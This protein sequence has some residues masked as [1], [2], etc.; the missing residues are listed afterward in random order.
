MI[1]TTWNNG[2]FS[3]DG[4]GYGIRFSKGNMAFLKQHGWNELILQLGYNGVEV[5]CKINDTFWTT[6][7]EVR[8]KMIGRFLIINNMGKWVTGKPFKLSLFQ[9]EENRFILIKNNH[10]KLET[11]AGRSDFS[12]VGNVEIGVRITFGNANIAEV[13]KEQFV[14]L[15]KT[16]QGKKTHI[17]TSR[18]AAAERSLG[19]WLQENVS[20]TALAS[21]VGAILVDEGYAEKDE[22]MIILH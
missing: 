2:G 17:G 5:H 19:H 15:L 21:Y 6:C 13:S 1:V 16:F 3:D 22:S 9:L 20:K 14:Q 7:P 4:I 11:W 18:N 12:Y 8:S 10:K